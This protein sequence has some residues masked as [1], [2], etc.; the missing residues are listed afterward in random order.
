MSLII[1]PSGGTLYVR[2]PIIATAAQTVFS[3]NYTVGYVEIY[4]NGLLLPAVDYTA[5]NGTSITLAVACVAGDIVETKTSV[6]A[7]ST[8][9]TTGKAIAMAMIFGG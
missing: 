7:V 4:L 9:I 8:G 5:T 1:S 3:V 2:T 6:T